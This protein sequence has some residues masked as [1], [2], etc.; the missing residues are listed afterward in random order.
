MRGRP[1]KVAI[2]TRTSGRHGDGQGQ[3]YHTAESCSTCRSVC[4]RAHSPPAFSPRRRRR[5]AAQTRPGGAAPLG[6]REWRGRKA[7]A[8][9]QRAPTTRRSCD[10]TLGSR[11]QCH[12][13][14]SPGNVVK[15]P[16]RDPWWQQ[17]G[18]WQGGRQRRGGAGRGQ[19]APRRGRGASGLAGSCLAAARVE[20]R[21]TGIPS[22]RRG[23]WGDDV[24]QRIQHLD[25]LGSDNLSWEEESV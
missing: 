7:E 9:W 13:T 3:V 11:L 18:V 12:H 2:A 1:Y 6:G 20:E 22:W 19:G 25:G 8:A 16:R 14:W 21:H 23:G 15:D 10:R 17:W 4:E 24:R 5:P